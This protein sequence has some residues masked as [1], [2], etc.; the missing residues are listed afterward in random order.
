MNLQS[1]LFWNVIVV[2]VIVG[3]FASPLLAARCWYLELRRRFSLEAPRWRSELALA[4]LALASVS[5]IMS[6][7]Y[8][9]RSVTR[10]GDFYSDPLLE[11][12]MGGGLFS[13]ILALPCALVGKGR[14]RWPSLGIGL[15]MAFFWF[16]S[17]MSV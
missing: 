3:M 8:F 5:V 4:A 10:G 9:L 2:I 11:K 1:K 17:A 7:G 16:M 12:F 15:F 13:A 6:L 14:A